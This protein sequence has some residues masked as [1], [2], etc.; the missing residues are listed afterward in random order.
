MKKYKVLSAGVVVVRKERDQWLFLLLR[1]YKYWDFPKGIVEKGEDPIEGAKREVE[2]ETTIN[3]LDF[4]WGHEY[5]DTG[6]Y[7]KGKIARYYLAE[8]RQKDVDLPVNPEIG[9]PEHHEFR[10]VPYE[11]ALELV[12]NRVKPVVRWAY[13]KITR[14]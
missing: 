9:M 3:Q 1:A 14:G 4:K 5:V 6:P 7:N 8:T 13:E 10:W 12:G 11:E 2:E